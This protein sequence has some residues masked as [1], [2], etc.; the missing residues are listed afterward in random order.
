MADIVSKKKRSQM[1]AGI[2]GKNTKPE[3]A[4]RKA[5]F[6]KG[7]RYRLHKKN[8]PGKP[9]LVLA[10]YNTVIFIHGCFWHR[11]D[12]HLFKWPSTR[13]EFWKDKINGN[14]TRDLK[15]LKELR[16]LKWR[17][18]VIWECA[19]KGKYKRPLDEITM[20]TEKFLKSDLE[21]FQ[22]ENV[23]KCPDYHSAFGK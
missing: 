21:E 19:W 14:K 16:E 20:L 18:L 6:K 7:Y 2:K 8:L 12:C 11:H 9:D 15:H 4:I 5:L 1:M 22:I 23:N 13:P 3:V 10:K 17:V